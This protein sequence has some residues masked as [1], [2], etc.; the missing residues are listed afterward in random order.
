MWKPLTITRT[1]SMRESVGDHGEELSCAE[2]PF[3]GEDFVEEI[4]RDHGSYWVQGSV[5]AETVEECEHVEDVDA[6]EE[7]VT[8]VSRTLGEFLRE[9]AP[10]AA[11]GWDLRVAR[12]RAKL[13][14]TR[15]RLQRRELI[16]CWSCERTT[17]QTDVRRTS[18]ESSMPGM[19]LSSRCTRCRATNSGCD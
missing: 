10:R 15:M 7:V 6:C 1:V 17:E 11:A 8:F 14:R 12:V 18:A 9:M 19:R 13:R 16:F 2:C 4:T 3:C 5:D